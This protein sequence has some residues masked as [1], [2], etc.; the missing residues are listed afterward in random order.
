MPRNMNVGALWIREQNG[1]KT[2][3][4]VIDLGLLG[5]FNVSLKKNP[6]SDKTDDGDYILWS[7]KDNKIVGEFWIKEHVNSGEK[8]VFMNGNIQIGLQFFNVNIFKNGFKNKDK[9]PDY[10]ITMMVDK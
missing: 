7:D 3:G 9:Q 10:K 2:I 6:D 5:N 4:G 1:H 8:M